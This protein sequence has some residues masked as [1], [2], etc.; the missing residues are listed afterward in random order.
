MF[1]GTS[2]GY[3]HQSSLLFKTAWRVHTHLA[4][5]DGIF[6]ANDKDGIKLQSLCGMNRHERHTILSIAIF[7][8]LNVRKQRHLLQ[9][10]REI[11]IILPTLFALSLYEVVDRRNEGI[12]IL[13]T[14]FA[15]YRHVG[16]KVGHDAAILEDILAKSVG[17]GNVDLSHKTIYKLLK[18]VELGESSLVDIELIERRIFQQ[19]PEANAVFYGSRSKF[20][21]CCVAYATS[22]IVDHTTESLFVIRIGYKSEICHH[23]LYLL[24][25]IEALTAKDGIR[26][27]LL[28]QFLLETSTKGVGT[29]KDSEVG[30]LAILTIHISLNGIAN[31]DS[32]FLI[33]IGLDY[34][35]LVALLILAIHL[36]RY[37]PTVFLHDAV[38]S[39]ND[40]LSGTIVALKLEEQSI[41][42]LMLE[43]EDVVDIGTTKGVDT[44][45]VVANYADTLVFTSKE[46]KYSLLSIVGV[47]ILIHEHIGKPLGIFSPY[48]L[49]FRKQTESENQQ[50]VEV[51]SISLE[52]SLLIDAIYFCCLRYLR[53]SITLGNIVVGS[54]SFGSHKFVFSQ[55]NMLMHG[56]R[57]I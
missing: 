47:L 27:I 34:R 28:A 50:V 12:D 14:S 15:L 57:L 32:L 13:T 8:A 11:N 54:I 51:H 24:T 53:T 48:R 52:E 9:I 36:L 37:L 2:H 21:N 7:V 23:I 55:R 29:I 3:V 4:W 20:L 35:N 42:I 26:N 56:S 5:E 30:I 31:H 6:Y 10:V 43:V 16:S 19:S 39:F 41:R 46:S 25:L 22:R 18:A 45:V 33:R 40:S 44:L 38:G 1:L 17:I 49:V